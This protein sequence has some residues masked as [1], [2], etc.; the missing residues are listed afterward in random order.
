MYIIQYI[1]WLCLRTR[2]VAMVIAAAA[3]LLFA[4]TQPMC[5]APSVAESVRISIPRPNSSNICVRIQKGAPIA[6]RNSLVQYA[7]NICHPR[8]YSFDDYRLY[9]P[10]NVVYNEISLEEYIDWLMITRAD[11]TCISD[12]LHQLRVPIRRG[13]VCASCRNCIGDWFIHTYTPDRLLSHR[14][15]MCT[16][17]NM[18]TDSDA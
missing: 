5:A 14:S 10:F 16:C 3:R 7:Y 6:G 9:S 12:V 13:S 18:D 1:A 2:W 15:V 4:Y 11:C 17:Y 8:P